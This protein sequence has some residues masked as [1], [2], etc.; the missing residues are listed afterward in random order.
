MI[1]IRQALETDFDGI[2]EIIKVVLRQGDTYPHSPTTNRE[3]A[4]E[5]WMTTSTAAFI[6]LDKGEILGTYYL[7]PNQPDLGSHV[8]NGGYMVKPGA[9]NRG[10]GTAMG[11]HSIA[12]AKRLGFKSMQFNLIVATNES[13]IRLWNKLGF[14]LVGTL[15][16]AFNHKDFGFVDAFV[17]YKLL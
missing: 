14:D 11:K 13:S 4:F 12:E 8:C 9:R 3:E 15:P 2:W 5:Y 17:M 16:K 10:I 7:R 1:E 6:A